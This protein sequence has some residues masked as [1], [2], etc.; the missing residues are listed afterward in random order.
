MKIWGFVLHQLKMPLAMCLRFMVGCFLSKDEV[1]TGKY[2]D[3]RHLF[4]LLRLRYSS[5]YFSSFGPKALKRR[6]PIKPAAAILPVPPPRILAIA[7][8]I[9]IKAKKARMMMS[10]MMVPKVS[11]VVC[12]SERIDCEEEVAVDDRFRSN[13]DETS[14]CSDIDGRDREII[15]SAETLIHNDKILSEC[16]PIRRASHAVRDYSV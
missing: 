12:L 5:T 11:I 4:W 16:S 3:V 14:I 13:R 9:V 7:L 15:D 2:S 6:K 8:I 1:L 10:M